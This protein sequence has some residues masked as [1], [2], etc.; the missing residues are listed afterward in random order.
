MAKAKVV[1]EGD[2][3]KAIQQVD[4]LTG[5]VQKLQR[6]LSKAKTTGKKAGDDTAGALGRAGGEAMRFAAAMT[7]VGSAVGGVMMIVNQL[8]REYENLVQRQREAAQTQ[9]S[10]AQ[11][12]AGALYQV[13]SEM[14]AEAGAI[15][16]RIA[17]RAQVS[18]AEVWRAYGPAWS[19]KGP[20]PMPAF[21]SALGVGM[22]LRGVI[23][24]EFQAGPFAG[25]LMDI[26]RFTGIQQGQ[27][28]YGYAGQFGRAARI[29]DPRLQ[30]RALAQALAAGVPRG[31]TPERVG[32]L[33]AYFTQMG[34]DP[35]GELST[36]GLIN[37]MT[38]LEKDIYPTEGP[39][40]RV[41]WGPVPGATGPERLAALQER[42]RKAS[43]SLRREIFGKIGGEA[44]VLE[45]IQGLLLRKPGAMGVLRAAE[46][47][48]TPPTAQGLERAFE[49]YMAD[50]RQ[51]RVQPVKDVSLALDK[52]TEE[53]RRTSPE[54]LAGAIR[55][56][57]VAGLRAA[58]VSDI[59]QRME[60]WK[61]EKEAVF[62]TQQDVINVTFGILSRLKSKAPFAPYKVYPTKFRAGA[63]GVGA[64]EE[65]GRPFAVS[66]GRIEEMRSRGYR[67]E[68]H[69]EFRP[70]S[71]EDLRALHSKLAQIDDRLKKGLDVNLKSSD[72][73][74]TE[75][76]TPPPGE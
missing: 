75:T 7:G 1:F 72:L 54:A 56:R 11:A 22:T 66:E 69:P 4:K 41:T 21:E 42:L 5:Q 25:G 71:L 45:A 44:K 73:T 43:P 13:P 29:V 9:L 74:K 68:P 2:A 64:A 59:E 49:Q 48:I 38:R 70:E 24:P 40:G 26:M 51:G 65:E 12:R 76:V 37:L 46:T 52:F 3:A 32:E 58:G 53:M 35:T 10:L 57:L 18:Q 36:T 15:V 23:G 67:I 34:A 6:Q 31:F 16:G 62:G 17:T 55:P 50:I 61:F 33:L 20:L 27:R 39:R 8:K 60:K 19:A 47:A 28:A 63:F 14:R 30:T